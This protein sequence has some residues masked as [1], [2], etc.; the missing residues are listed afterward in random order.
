MGKLIFR[1]PVT[2]NWIVTDIHTDLS[3]LKASWSAAARVYCPHCKLH[4]ELPMREAWVE[5]AA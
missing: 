4:H 3:S 5:E 1:C 2:A